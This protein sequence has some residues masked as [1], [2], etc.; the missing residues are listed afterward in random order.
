MSEEL[1]QEKE[2]K[3]V[4]IYSYIANGKQLW[5]SNLEFAKLR[6]NFYGT[7]NV[8]VEKTDVKNLNN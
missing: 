2:I 6:A 1:N 8:Y 7:N 4:E 5:T 3:E